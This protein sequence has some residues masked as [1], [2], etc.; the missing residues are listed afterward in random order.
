MNDNDCVNCRYSKLSVKPESWKIDLYCKKSK[1]FLER[2]IEIK[3]IYNTETDQT[4]KEK[5]SPPW[6]CPPWCKG[7]KK[8]LFFHGVA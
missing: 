1:R 7:F 3:V 5:Q 8:R 2:I 4:R 6:N